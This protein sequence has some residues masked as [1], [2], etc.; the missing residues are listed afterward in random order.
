MPTSPLSRKAPTD[1]TNEEMR[2][3]LEL[4]CEVYGIPPATSRGDSVVRVA[5]YSYPHNAVTTTGRQCH[6]IGLNL[7]E[8][9]GVAFFPRSSN[10]GVA[11]VCDSTIS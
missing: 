7:F 1:W 6:A 5:T 8:G 10:R 3:A 11:S 9:G 4:P 2:S